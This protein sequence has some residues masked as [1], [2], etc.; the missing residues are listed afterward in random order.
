MGATVNIGI[1]PQAGTATGS[2]GVAPRNF[3]YGKGT[4]LGVT[5]AYEGLTLV[6]MV[7]K[8]KTKPN[9]DGDVDEFNGSW[10]ANYNRSSFSRLSRNLFDAGLNL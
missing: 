1:T 3:T 7:L 4:G 2:D 8:E 10:F 9:D 5:I 6:H